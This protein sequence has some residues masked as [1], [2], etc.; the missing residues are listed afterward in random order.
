MKL[1]KNDIHTVKI[2]NI[3]N[4]GFGVARIGGSV[5]FVADTVPGDVIEC[6]IIKVGASFCV[7]RAERIISRS[8]LFCGT[9]C[10]N[11][12]CKS[13]AYK[14]LSYKTELD[15][16]TD[17]VRHEM[18]KA[19]LSD[20]EVLDTT[21]SPTTVQYRN[22]AQYP[23]M[24]TK[25]GVA[26]GFFAPK[27]HRVTEASSCILAH[28]SFEKILTTVRAIIDKHGIVAYNE[29]DGSGIFRHI[30]LRRGEISGEI[31]LTLVING[32]A[33]PHEN[34]FIEKITENH[35]DVVGILLNKNSR[36]TNVILSDDY[37]TLWGRNYLYDTLADVRLKISAPAFYQVNH[38]TAELI[39]KRAAEFAAPKKSDTLLDLYCG[40][41]SI[42]LSMAKYA[43]EVIG[44]EIID[45]AVKC[46]NQ[47]AKINGIKN[48]RFFTGDAA[49]AEGLLERAQRELGRK[50]EPNIIILDPPRAG[51]DDRLISYVASLAPQR[52]VYISCNPSTLARDIS[53]FK[54]KGYDTHV[55]EPF[56]MF[57]MT[58]HVETIVCLCKQ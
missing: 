22:K 2:E 39:Y 4:L 5:V 23:L 13:C 58:G 37:E 42:G 30:Y 55:V 46:A 11:A 24:N 14:N 25:S 27:S 32:E 57:P 12:L 33:L 17:G 3:T 41:G 43:G 29:E 20:I 26:I 21:P 1:K 19:G 38:G 49:D 18:R 51:C 50:I 52:I 48:A 56:D 45:D 9:R 15:I 8:E 10:Q 31:L 40:T 54:E 44:I 36:N 53:R 47:N 35:P 16:K 7:G 6:K 34:E 28:P